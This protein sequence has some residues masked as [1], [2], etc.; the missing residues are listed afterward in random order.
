MGNGRE[1]R[2]DT[3]LANDD[4]DDEKEINRKSYRRAPEPFPSYTA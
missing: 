3:D 1:P 4:T 2:R